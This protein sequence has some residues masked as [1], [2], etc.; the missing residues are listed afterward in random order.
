MSRWERDLC[1]EN[2]IAM[3]NKRAN[4]ERLSH[5]ISMVKRSLDLHKTVDKPEHPIANRLHIRY[6]T[7]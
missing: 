3:E 7:L 1:I 6:E 2:G 5:K 4:G